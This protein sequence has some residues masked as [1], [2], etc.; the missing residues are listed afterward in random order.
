MPFVVESVHGGLVLH[1][2]LRPG[3]SCKVGFITPVQR[4]GQIR[5]GNRHQQVVQKRDTRLESVVP[6]H[7]R[8]AH[9]RL[10]EPDRQNRKHFQNRGQPGRMASE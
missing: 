9:V 1:G 3:Q 10:A 2:D 5:R 7:R 8:D 6:V 4:V